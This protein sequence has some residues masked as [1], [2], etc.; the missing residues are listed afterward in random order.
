[1]S[2]TLYLSPPSFDGFD[3]GAGARDQSRRE[4]AIFWHT[5]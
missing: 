1:M 5:A 2:R 3:G 4:V